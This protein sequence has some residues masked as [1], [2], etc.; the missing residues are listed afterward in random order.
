MTNYE[1]YGDSNISNLFS[2]TWFGRNLTLGSGS[3]VWKNG[4][5]VILNQPAYQLNIPIN[6]LD[7]PFQHRSWRW[8]LNAFQWMDKLLADFKISQDEVAIQTCVNYFFDWADFYVVRSQEGEFLWK[9]D[10]VSF[11]TL[12]LS[13]V[14]EYILKSGR[15]SE[16]EKSL[17]TDI[18][19]RHYVELSDPKKFKSNNHGIFQMRALMGLLAVHPDIG[20]LEES[21]K[22]VVRRLNWLWEKQYGS[23]NLHLENSTGYHQYIIKEFEAILESPEFLALRFVFDKKKLE[24]VKENTKFLFHPSGIGTLFGD[25]NYI[26]EKHAVVIGDHIFNEAGYAILAGTDNTQRNSYLAIRTGFPSNAHR[27]SDDFSFE[28]SEKGQVIFQDSGRYSYDYQNP[29]RK[30]VSSSRAHNTIAINGENFPWWGNFKQKDFYHD[31]IRRYCG[32]QYEAQLQLEKEFSDLGVNFKR[33]FHIE[34]GKSLRIVDTLSSTSINVYEQ[35]FHLTEDFE[36]LDSDDSKQLLFK[37]HC[38]TIR[39]DVPNEVEVIVVKGQVKPFIQGWVSYKEKQIIPRWSIG[40][41]AKSK[42]F[43]FDTQILILD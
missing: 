20:D 14:A 1:Y 7:D 22:Y 40:F 19:V 34:R 30:F 11:R 24:V 42:D 31:A 25:S 43:C 8:I 12:R 4:S 13:I 38:L 9:D 35:W 28:W 41:R 16:E 15:Y 17:T 37:S 33:M 26:E 18:L 32:N 27:H 2:L 6:W 3:K 39:V 23:Q 29:Y 5:V 10:A 21:K 36:Y